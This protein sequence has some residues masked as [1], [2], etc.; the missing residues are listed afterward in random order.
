MVLRMLSHDL[1]PYMN[2]CEVALLH[3]NPEA[4]TGVFIR[5]QDILDTASLQ[6]Q[7]DLTILI[8]FA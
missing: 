5:Y 3:P 4:V 2:W 7:R 8:P 1:Q 6:N